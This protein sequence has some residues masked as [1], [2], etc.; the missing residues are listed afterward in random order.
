VFQETVFVYSILVGNSRAK[1]FPD[2]LLPVFQLIHAVS[3]LYQANSQH[4]LRNRIYA[5][6]EL[7]TLCLAS[8]KL[9]AKRFSTET[10]SEYSAR[11]NQEVLNRKLIDLSQFNWLDY[12][13]DELQCLNRFHKSVWAQA[14]DSEKKVIVRSVNSGGSAKILHAELNI[15]RELQLMG[16][17]GWPKVKKIVV[18]LKPCKMCAAL[19]CEFVS[20]QKIS[21]S[22][23][24]L[25][26]DTGP[27]A[28]NTV[29]DQFDWHVLQ[30]G[31]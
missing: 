29:L 16:A 22:V 14:F 2:H 18:S 23:T 6:Y 28:Q 21:I 31:I 25:Q 17:A 19:L 10:E 7:S 20:N 11:K 12:K 13:F 24:Y 5:N 3:T 30:L 26:N 4:I 8:V 15:A 27:M 9:I 1:K